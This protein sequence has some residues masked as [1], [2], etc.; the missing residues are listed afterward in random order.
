[1][2]VGVEKEE[3][4]RLLFFMRR[5]EREME[6][7]RRKRGCEFLAHSLPRKTRRR[8]KRG[9]KSHLDVPE[10]DP[11]GVALRQ[12]PQ[13]RPRD[14]GNPGLGEGAAAGRLQDGAAG[15]EL[16]FSFFFLREREKGNERK[17]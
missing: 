7:R 13:D 1:M 11:F 4:V 3:V 12:E 15:A 5:R 14:V 17:E 2:L 9:G 10:D 6:G 8:R 16:L